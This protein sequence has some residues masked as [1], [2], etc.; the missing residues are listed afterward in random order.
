MVHLVSSREQT[1]K[2]SNYNNRKSRDNREIITEKLINNKSS[3]NN[4]I[5]TK[6]EKENTMI[7][8]N[9]EEYV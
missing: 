4:I 3:E 6:A 9:K 2:K 7:A 8:I 5:F 1:L